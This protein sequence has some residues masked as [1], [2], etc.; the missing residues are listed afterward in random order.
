MRNQLTKHHAVFLFL[1]SI[2][3]CSETQEV[4]R[5]ASP[6]GKVQ[7]IITERLGASAVDSDFTKVSLELRPNKRAEIFSGSDMDG[8]TATWTSDNSLIVKYDSGYVER[9]VNSVPVDGGPVGAHIVVNTCQL[10]C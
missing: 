10:P 2:C 5:I 3:G 6:D 9:I 4:E 1:F 7:A 8:V